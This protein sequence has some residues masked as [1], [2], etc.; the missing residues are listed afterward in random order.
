MAT[1]AATKLRQKGKHVCVAFIPVALDEGS[2]LRRETPKIVRSL[3][4][5]KLR[6][7]LASS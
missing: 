1:Q 4:D 2:T 3:T 5:Q 6:R 7:A